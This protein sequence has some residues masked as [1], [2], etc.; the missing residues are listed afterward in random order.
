MRSPIRAGRKIGRRTPKKRFLDV[1]ET[2][3]T[4]ALVDAQNR[5]GWYCLWEDGMYHRIWEDEQFDAKNAYELAKLFSK[6]NTEHYTKYD[7]IIVLGQFDIMTV[8][9]YSSFTDVTIYRRY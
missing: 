8:E 5:P 7:E 1:F 9:K 6:C 4:V 2:G 3:Q